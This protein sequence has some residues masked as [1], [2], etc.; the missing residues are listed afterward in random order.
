MEWFIDFWNNIDWSR[1]AEFA[2]I[3]GACSAIT[4]IIMFAWEFRKK[5][6]S[7]GR[8]TLI[9][10][11]FLRHLFINTAIIELVRHRIQEAGGYDRVYPEEGV[12][13][14]MKFLP[15]DFRLSRFRSSD[16]CFDK[17]HDLEL[18]MR[19]YGVSLDIANKHLSD[20]RL[21]DTYKTEALEDLKKRA[22]ALII[23]IYSLANDL[24]LTNI[25]PLHQIISEKYGNK[26]NN[27][28][29]DAKG[30]ATDIAN[31]SVPNDNFWS[32]LYNKEIDESLINTNELYTLYIK[33]FIYRR[34]NGYVRLIEFP[35]QK[36]TKPIKPAKRTSKKKTL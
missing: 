4:G 16:A 24:K 1:V 29:E 6:I 5:K 25:R 23:N 28:A 19:N 7:D 15:E 21:P 3:L 33:Y 34:D 12:F 13:E 31:S 14:R 10:Q 2:T 17:M 35:Q 32:N 11:D 20:P 18:L 9:F 27:T 8:K 22:A 30:T 36:P 26:I